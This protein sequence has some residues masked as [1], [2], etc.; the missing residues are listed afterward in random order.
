MKAVFN[1]GTGAQ[2]IQLV[3]KVWFGGLT[4]EDYEGEEH[5]VAVSTKNQPQSVVNISPK[6]DICEL[7][8]CVF[9]P[10]EMVIT[11]SGDRVCKNCSK[12]VT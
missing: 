12:K 5:P 3:R 6:A 2:R 7:C 4:R 10:E 8:E 11:G 9:P 1:D